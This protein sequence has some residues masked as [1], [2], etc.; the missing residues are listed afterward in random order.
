MSGPSYF[1][2][3]TARNKPVQ[4]FL[5]HRD[6]KL[7]E[8]R[9]RHFLAT[10]P[11][12]IEALFKGK[13]GL[14]SFREKV[15]WLILRGSL[16]NEGENV[17]EKRSHFQT[18]IGKKPVQEDWEM[19]K[20]IFSH[21]MVAALPDGDNIVD[22]MECAEKYVWGVISSLLFP[23]ISAKDLKTVQRITRKFARTMGI[24]VLTRGKSLWWDSLPTY[25]RKNKLTKIL[26][27]YMSEPT[28][29]LTHL[30]EKFKGKEL[31]DTI[32]MLL[33]AATQTT[34]SALVTATY[35]I[36]TYLS[37]Q[38]NVQL[39]FENAAWEAMRLLPPAMVVNVFVRE[40]FVVDGIE[41]KGSDVLLSPIYGHYDERVYV[42]P[43]EFNPFRKL[44]IGKN[45]LP[46]GLG[47]RFCLGQPMAMKMI[48]FWL[49]WLFGRYHVRIVGKPSPRLGLET[50][51]V[52]TKAEL[53]AKKR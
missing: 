38:G 43:H 47:P 36:A 31:I 16:L 48:V 24:R 15:A 30:K 20:D 19:Y 5:K 44:E 17:R 14:P 37:A 40:S 22:I 52:N 18:V 4:G 13:V 8:F 39:D 7:H 34:K 28:H 23:T 53:K 41:L 26:N 46:F 42:N 50:T 32:T 12:L 45:L 1:F 33:I 29:L 25:L 11:D 9:E 49:E 35:Y 3:A 10:D 6:K 51:F 27:K 2:P 21:A